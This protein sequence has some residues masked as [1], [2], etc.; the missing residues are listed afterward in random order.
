MVRRCWP[1]SQPDRVA[2][3]AS[4]CLGARR[5][6]IADFYGTGTSDILWRNTNGAVDIWTEGNPNEAALIANV[7]T[8]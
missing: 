6:T 5:T 8:S 2:N 1:L 3:L 7:D 4:V